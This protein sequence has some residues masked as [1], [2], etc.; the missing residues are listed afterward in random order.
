[1]VIFL[2][3]IVPA[4]VV[5]THAYVGVES[6]AAQV[7]RVSNRT[8]ILSR[9]PSRRNQDRKRH[10]NS[11]GRD[12]LV[13][14]SRNKDGVA[15]EN[16]GSWSVCTH[17]LEYGLNFHVRLGRA[18]RSLMIKESLRSLLEVGSGV[19]LYTSFLAKHVPNAV[20]IVGVE[21]QNIILK[22]EFGLRVRVAGK[23]LPRQC[24]IDVL[25]A[26]ASALAGYDLDKS[27]DVVF[28]SEVLEHIPRSLHP[29][30]L[31]FLVA[32]ASKFVVLGVP[33][34]V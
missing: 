8:A 30:F 23:E 26:S 32:R 22:R 13:S 4:V 15:G 21:P 3:C 33:R 1:M 10:P 14:G 19:G 20:D 7:G 11:S 17:L 12:K 34:V 16:G 5:I 2:H 31:D 9:N 25:T 18:L 24:E 28:S 29:K 6:A 27:F